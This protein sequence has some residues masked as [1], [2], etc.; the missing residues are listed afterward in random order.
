[1]AS[2]TPLVSRIVVP[3]LSQVA[4]L[5]RL[6]KFIERQATTYR[7]EYRCTPLA[8]RAPREGANSNDVAVTNFLLAVSKLTVLRLRREQVVDICMFIAVR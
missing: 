1:L 8:N 3:L 2:I 4:G 6:P 7:C 5:W